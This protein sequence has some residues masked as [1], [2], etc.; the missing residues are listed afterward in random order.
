[1]IRVK[2]VVKTCKAYPAQWGGITEDMR[3]VY[4]HY[5]YGCLEIYLGNVGDM[6]DF[7]FAG[8]LDKRVLSV[9]HGDKLD[10]MLEYSELKILSTGIV[11]FPE[12]E[13]D[14]IDWQIRGLKS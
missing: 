7:E 6:S 2:K 12:I 10:G 11:E 3:Q 1:M 13:S 8:L 9:V 5:R 14:V 4:V